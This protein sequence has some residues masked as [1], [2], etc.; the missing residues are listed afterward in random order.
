MTLESLFESELL[1]EVYYTNLSMVEGVSDV[2]EVLSSISSLDKLE[3]KLALDDG[4]KETVIDAISEA[5]KSILL[6]RLQF[7]DFIQMMSTMEEKDVNSKATEEKFLL[8]RAKILELNQKIQELSTDVSKLHPL[9]NTIPEYSETHDNKKYQLLETLKAINISSTTSMSLNI[10]TPIPLSAAATPTT[11]GPSVNMSGI[12]NAAAGAIPA[13]T[14]RRN[15]STAAT[16]VSSNNTPIATGTASATPTSSS[17][18][19]ASTNKKPRK[20]RQPKKSSVTAKKQPAPSPLNT[21]VPI[22]TYPGNNI[23]E[24]HN[25]GNIKPNYNPNVAVPQNAMNNPSQ[26][27]SNV[28]PTNMVNTPLNNMMGSLNGVVNDFSNM[29]PPNTMQIQIPPQQQQQQPQQ[30]INMNMNMNM[31]N[32][33][34]ANILSMTLPVDPQMQQLQNQKT[35][36]RSAPQQQQQRTLSGLDTNDF[37]LLDLNN[38]DFGGSMDFV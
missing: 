32:I 4:S 2:S 34:P 38:L 22:N 11:T 9:F 36:Q 18:S 25:N 26:I 30:Q 27:M 33:T 1:L 31:N 13:T 17:A 19:I 14:V 6:M 5:Q 12:N 16:P 8:I 15:K 28:S 37:D 10:G 20:P 21:Q 3:E 24:Y 7:N 35:Q 29:Q 23:S